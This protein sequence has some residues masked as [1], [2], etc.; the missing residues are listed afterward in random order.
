MRDHRTPVEKAKKTLNGSLKSSGIRTDWLSLLACPELRGSWDI[1]I[2]MLKLT[3]S[4]A[5]WD[6]SVVLVKTMMHIAKLQEKH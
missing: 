1:G 5:N 3:K 4:Q 2:S 6:E